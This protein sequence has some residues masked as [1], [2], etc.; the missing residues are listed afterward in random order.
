MTSKA[1]WYYAISTFLQHINMFSYIHQIIIIRYICP[2][3]A[4]GLNFNRKYWSSC[5]CN[6]TC[7]EGEKVKRYQHYSQIRMH[8]EEGT[9]DPCWIT[10]IH[11]WGPRGKN[12][13]KPHGPRFFF[14][15]WILVNHESLA[16]NQYCLSGDEIARGSFPTR[17]IHMYG[18]L[19]IGEYIKLPLRRQSWWPIYHYIIQKEAT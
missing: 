12:C 5:Q 13:C 6:L 15:P 3:S 17:T 14:L 11:W 1:P 9:P 10:Y 16:S 18:L 19:E 8:W 4:N 7:S 2:D